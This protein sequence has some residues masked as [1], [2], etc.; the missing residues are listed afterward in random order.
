MFDLPKNYY[1]VTS[2]RNWTIKSLA[3]FSSWFSKND[4]NIQSQSVDKQ[5]D[6]KVTPAMRVN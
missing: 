1:T 6:I 5:V 4:E 2:S 3:K